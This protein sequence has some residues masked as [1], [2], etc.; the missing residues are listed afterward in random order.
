MSRNDSKK[1]YCGPNNTPKNSRQGSMKECVKKKKICLYG[2]KKVDSRTV[3]YYKQKQV[4][5][6]K[7]YK[8]YA[9]LM[10]VRNNLTKRIDGMKDKTKRAE[11]KNELEIVNED[12]SK[13]RKKLSTIHKN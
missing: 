5:N 11:L 7:L 6:T 12:I 8:T 2:L 9:R 10:G 13:V 1:I 4:S 3:T